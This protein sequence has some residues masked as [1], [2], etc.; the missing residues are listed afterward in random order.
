MT[1][2]YIP[3]FHGSSSNEPGRFNLHKIK[4]KFGNRM[5]VAMVSYSGF[6]PERIKYIN[7]KS[8]TGD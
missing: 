5:V 4:L 6:K 2:H 8:V 3:L 1:V 7:S